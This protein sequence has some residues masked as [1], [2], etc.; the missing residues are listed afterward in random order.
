MR[1]LAVDYG[2]RRIGLAVCDELEWGA[3]PLKT[4]TRSRSLRHDLGEIARLAAKEEAGGIV[5]G[6]PVNA[7]GSHGPSAEAAAQ[8]ARSLGKHTDLPIHLHDEFLTT[9]EAEAE[10]IAADVSRKRR[11]EVIDQMA[12]VHILES[13]LRARKEKEAKPA[14]GSE[15]A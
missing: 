4:L 8:F 14:E 6:L 2:T 5:V 12:A 1:Y 11:R 7:D 13:F 10:L 9:A 15:D 3:F